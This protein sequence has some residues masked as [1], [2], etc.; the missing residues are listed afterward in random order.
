MGL[1]AGVLIGLAVAEVLALPLWSHNRG[2]GY[3]PAVVIGI[4][5]IILLGM[6]FTGRIPGG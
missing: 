3:G 2:W 1:A 4:V 5:I 6:T